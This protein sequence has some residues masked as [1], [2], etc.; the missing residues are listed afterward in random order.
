[1][2]IIYRGTKYDCIKFCKSVLNILNCIIPE[3]MSCLKTFHTGD[4]ARYWLV[5]EIQDFCL[6]SMSVERFGNL[7]ECCCGTPVGMWAAVNH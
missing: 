6:Y 2:T 5:A 4:T 1:M 3:T 7:V